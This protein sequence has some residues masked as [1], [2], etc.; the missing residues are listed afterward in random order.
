MLHN[1]SMPRLIIF[2]FFLALLT[3][4]L[5]GREAGPEIRPEPGEN[6]RR[7]LQAGDYAG[8]AAAYLNLAEQDEPR[9]AAYRLEAAR[10]YVEAGLFEEAR[11]LLKTPAAAPGDPRQAL[12]HEVLTARLELESG[13]AAAALD[14]LKQIPETDLPR[15]LRKIYHQSLARAYL[16]DNAY[17]DAARQR[18]RLQSYLPL[19]AERQQNTRALWAIFAAI[20]PARLNVLRLSASDEALLSWLELAAIYRGDRFRPAAMESAIDAWLARYPGHAAAPVIAPELLE[21]ATRLAARPTRIGLLLPFSGPYGQAA[22]AI[23]DGFLSAWY[24]DAGAKAE[25]ALYDSDALNIVERYRQ[26]AEDGVD[27]VIG[28]LEKEAV[29][30]LIRQ[31]DLP[32][33]VLALNRG[34]LDQGEGGPPDKLIQFGLSPED[35]ARQVAEVALA[36]GHSLALVLSPD[37][38]WGQRIAAAFKARWVG[39]GGA[40]LEH[41]YFKSNSLDYA[42]AVKALLNIDASEQRARALR[43]RMNRKIH[44]VERR[45]QD[46]DFIFVAA[47]PADAYQLF[48]QLRYHRATDLPVYSTSHIY[49]GAADNPRDIDLEGA[50]FIDMPWLLDGR[51]QTSAI[52]TAL[53]RNWAQDKSAYRRLYALGIDAYHLSARP[54]RLAAGDNTVFSGATGDLTVTPANAIRRKLRQARFIEGKPVMLEPAP[55]DQ[56]GAPPAAAPPA[57]APPGAAGP[58]PELT[59]PE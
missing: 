50:R 57:A 32:V 7:L 18:L 48:P 10:A 58:G 52:Q 37:I 41:V 13:R 54:G 43:A 3:A 23:R 30:Q 14:L 51:R 29:N 39:L 24:L 9:A 33:R 31:G 21:Q 15:A 34:D 45:R 27:F 36:D 8:A 11:A 56:A 59:Q 1:M 53:N 6:A 38:A 12:Y 16:A 49:S 22:A 40:V 42:A 46:A 28:P 4:C 55:P 25:I 5:P 20:P 19:P 26:A 17:E 35:E 47:V 44:S 2:I